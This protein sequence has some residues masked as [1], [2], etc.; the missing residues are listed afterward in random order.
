M[1][2]RRDSKVTQE[3]ADPHFA[4]H[5]ATI[6]P[7]VPLFAQPHNPA[8]TAMAVLHPETGQAQEYPALSTN[9]ATKDTWVRSFANKLGRL[10]QGV[11]NRVQGT[12]TIFFVPF[13]AVPTDRTVTYGRIV[14]D[15][16]PQKSEPERTRL[17]VGGNLITYPYDVSTDTAK[18]VINSTISTPGARHM[19]ID[20]K[21]YY[22]GT[23]LDIYEH[24]LG[25]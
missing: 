16:R 24:E 13:S 19:L 11:S 22:L 8:H 18:L 3:D 7:D 14:C 25:H 5:V 12:D 15:Y 6:Q 2:P 10:A 17:T 9:P 1:K 21:N 23:P 4:N 20:V